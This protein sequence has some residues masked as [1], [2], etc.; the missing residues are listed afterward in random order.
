MNLPR[1]QQVLVE[2][3]VDALV[4]TSWQNVFYVSGYEGFSQRLSPYTQVYALARAGALEAPTLIAPIGDLDMQ[5]QFPASLG[6][7]H[8][9]GRFYVVANGSGGPLEGEIAR[10]EPIALA[11]SGGTAVEALLDELAKL[12]PAARIAIDERGMASDAYAGVSAKLGERVVPGAALLDRIRMVKTDEEVRRLEAAA[13]VMEVSFQAAIDAAHEGMSEAEMGY[14]FDCRTLQQ[15]S[16]PVFTVIC[17]GERGVFPNAIPSSDRRL[18]RGDLIRFDIGCRTEM[19]SSDISR[20]AVFGEPSAKL[21][22]YYQ[23]ILEGEERA[24]Q[25]MRPGTPA[26][27][28]FDAAVRGTREGGIPHYERNHVGHAIGLDIYDLPI[29][30]AASETPLE[31]GMVFE[32]ETPYYELGWGGVQVED[33]VV[34]TANGHRLLTQ[35]SRDLFVI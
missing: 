9:Y 30:N 10:Y 18:R 31:A 15:G 35:L 3:G 21:R 4:A 8:P 33:T 27:D 17:F 13:R 14:V 28:V 25:M 6:S 29:I 11:E 2:A 34:I 16:A 12:P 20:T 24:I 7:L 1:A 5:A 22:S 19:Y 32:V 23:A 26:R